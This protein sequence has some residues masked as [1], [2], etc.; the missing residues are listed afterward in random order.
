MIATTTNTSTNTSDFNPGP[1]EEKERNLAPNPSLDLVYRAREALRSGVSWRR[2]RRENGKIYRWALRGNLETVVREALKYASGE[3]GHYE[4]ERYFVAADGHPLE[5][6]S[7][8]KLTGKF[9]LPLE[10][11]EPEEPLAGRGKGRRLTGDL[12]GVLMLAFKFGREEAAGWL[13]ALR[14]RMETRA[15]QAAEARRIYVE[16]RMNWNDKDFVFEAVGGKEWTGDTTRLAGLISKL[17]V[18][19]DAVETWKVR[20]LLA[21]WLAADDDG[22][23]FTV[24]VGRE[25]RD[26]RG[27]IN[28]RHYTLTPSG[29]DVRREEAIREADHRTEPRRNR[30]ES[31]DLVHRDFIAARLEK[32]WSEKPE[33]YL[34]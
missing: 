22:H 20:R 9:W 12:F 32:E 16:R 10:P 6:L 24:A 13:C 2:R 31:R 25:W 3:P 5:G 1:A 29:R 23:R 17:C 8:S 15:W 26:A 28:K 33:L 18:E 30:Y 19:E 21:R 4:T 27:R 7:I 11:V 14:E 34:P